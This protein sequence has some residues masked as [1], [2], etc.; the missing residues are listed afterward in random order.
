MKT[1]NRD[2]NGTGVLL[3]DL[4]TAART[5][6]EKQRLKHIAQTYGALLDRIE[7]LD[8]QLIADT[9]RRLEAI[10][11]DSQSNDGEDASLMQAQ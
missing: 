6:S 11:E 10:Q 4:A 5:V 1:L 9:N 8:K 3:K 7:L 2:I